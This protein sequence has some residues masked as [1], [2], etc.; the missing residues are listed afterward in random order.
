[1]I[2]DC[3]RATEQ[4]IVDKG[5]KSVDDVLDDDERIVDVSD[6]LKRSWR[7]GKYNFYKKAMEG[8]LFRHRIILRHTYNAGQKIRRLFEIYDSEDGYELVP[9]DYKDTTMENYETLIRDSDITKNHEIKDIM[10]IITIRNYIAGMTD[11]FVNQKL[12]E[13]TGI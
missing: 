6:D 3:V 13:Y 1:M 8:I 12:K 7:E 2:A 9:S 4:R 10:K 11:A 5:I